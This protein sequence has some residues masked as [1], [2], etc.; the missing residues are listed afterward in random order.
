MS[1]TEFYDVVDSKG[2]K[3]VQPELH[4]RSICT[5]CDT[6]HNVYRREWRQPLLVDEEEMR[7]VADMRAWNCCH[8]E[9][10]PADSYPQDPR[11]NA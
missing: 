9:E 10:H 4:Y 1:D 3:G 6:A 2:V 5:D 8:M 7:Y 11:D